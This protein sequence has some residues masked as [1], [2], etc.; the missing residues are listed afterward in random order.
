MRQDEQRAERRE[1]PDQPPQLGDLAER[2][3][4]VAP[5]E[6]DDMVRGG[7]SYVLTGVSHVATDKSYE[8]G[9]QGS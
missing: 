1:E 3:A 6:R 9:A 4:T 8:R 7:K 2:P 5:A